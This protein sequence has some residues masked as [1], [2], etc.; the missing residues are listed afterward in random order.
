MRRVNVYGPQ[1]RFA[2]A[3][4]T[5]FGGQCE[6][7]HGH[8]YAVAV[9]LD[10]DLTPD[11][12]VFDFVEL[13]RIVAALCDELDHTFLLPTENPSLSVVRSQGH[14]EISFGDRR[15]VIPEAEVR[16]LPIDNSTA[17]RLAEWLAGR[18]AGELLARGAENVSLLTLTVEE[19]P[20]QSGSFA[21]P[22]RPATPPGA[23]DKDQGT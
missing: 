17:E 10:G 9:Q 7:L 2:A 8:N 12:W 23:R 4:F 15:Y 16:A 1:L 18:L 11:S 21:L 5:T 13:R 19:A 6:P 14:C 22:L 3:H 20:G